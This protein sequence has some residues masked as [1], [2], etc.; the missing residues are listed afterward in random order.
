MTDI[1]LIAAIFGKVNV[2]AE[3]DYIV[4]AAEEILLNATK[5][6]SVDIKTIKT[7]VK[8]FV[9]TFLDDIVNSGVILESVD[10]GSIVLKLICP[11]VDSLIS[12]IEY[13]NSDQIAKR[14]KDISDA[15]STEV[16]NKVN[17]N[18]SINMASLEDAMNKL[19]MYLC[20]YHGIRIS[21][22][23]VCLN[24]MG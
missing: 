22:S 11:S 6:R 14:L 7:A 17:L 12:L 13:F 10:K 24:N 19:R 8:N 3:E 16:G 18:A 20:V 1:L 23:N 4:N 9:D 5:I 15:L 21:I 2:S